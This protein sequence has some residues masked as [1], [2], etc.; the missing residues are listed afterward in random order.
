MKTLTYTVNFI[1]INIYEKNT[2]Q[3]FQLSPYLFS[4]AEKKKRK[5]KQMEWETW[6]KERIIF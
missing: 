6:I 2:Y 4:F 3:V 5:K 1:E